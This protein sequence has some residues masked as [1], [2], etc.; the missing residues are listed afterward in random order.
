MAVYSDLSKQLTKS[1]SR[2]EKKE[3]GIMYI[4]LVVG[5]VPQSLS[6]PFLQFLQNGTI[7]VR[8]AGAI[9]NLESGLQIPADYIFTGDNQCLSRLIEEVDRN[10]SKMPK[11]EEEYG[12]SKSM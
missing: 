4:N 2:K 8:L 5:R 7:H 1:L 9:I 3:E 6:R 11:L 12:Q 10:Q